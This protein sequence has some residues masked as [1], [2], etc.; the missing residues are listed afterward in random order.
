[1]K[2][3]IYQC[4][5]VNVKIG[6]STIDTNDVNFCSIFIIRYVLNSFPTVCIP[7]LYIGYFL[8]K[9]RKPAFLYTKI[10]SNT[11]QPNRFAY[12]LSIKKNV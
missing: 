4:L 9:Q 1:M 3:Y 10:L 6:I 12:M 7:L 2:L 5:F 11:T 8:L